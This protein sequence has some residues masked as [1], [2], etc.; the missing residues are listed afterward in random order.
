MPSLGEQKKK[1]KKYFLC[2]L[3]TCPGHDACQSLLFIR[4]KAE[5]VLALTPNK[6]NSTL[7]KLCT[8]AKNFFL[9]YSSSA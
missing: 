4:H 8:T 1:K 5:Q 7:L 2:L 9:M 3:M 6:E